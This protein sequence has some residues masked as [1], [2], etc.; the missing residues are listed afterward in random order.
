[1]GGTHAFHSNLFAA[2]PAKRISATIVAAIQL[3]IKIIHFI[4]FLV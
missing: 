2:E 4:S 1:M 3:H